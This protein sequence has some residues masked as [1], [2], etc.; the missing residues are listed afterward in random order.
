MFQTY[1]PFTYLYVSRSKL[2]WLQ[3]LGSEQQS[4]HTFWLVFPR[5]A[6]KL[7]GNRTV[8]NICILINKPADFLSH[9]LRWTESPGTG[10]GECDILAL[11]DGHSL[12]H[13]GAL[14]PGH[15]LTSLLRCLPLLEVTSL[16]G[17]LPTLLNWLLNWHLLTNIR[18]KALI[19]KTTTNYKM[20]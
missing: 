5:S 10:W 17:H 7:Y 11:G 3:S 1:F 18:R 14:L 4:D 8:V 9:S 15:Q 2:S 12:L 19:R 6:P 20:R 13:T 16:P